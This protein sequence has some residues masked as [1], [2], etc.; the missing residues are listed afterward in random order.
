MN[1]DDSIEH[2]PAWDKL[3]DRISRSGVAICYSGRHAE[4]DTDEDTIYIPKKYYRTVPG[5]VMLL[6]EAGHIDQPTA[7]YIVKSKN[8]IAG[9]R[10]AIIWY[11]NNAWDNALDIARALD[12]EEEIQDMYYKDRKHCMNEYTKAIYAYKKATVKHIYEGYTLDN[13]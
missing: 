6:H 7:P 1:N 8:D 9:M 2:I 13:Q 5:L 12:I 4:Y 10:Q 3:V 11:E